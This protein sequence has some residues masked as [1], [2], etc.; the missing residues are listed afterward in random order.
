MTAMYTALATTTLSSSASS[1]TF[2][3]IPQG[4]RDLMLVFNGEGTGDR[5]MYINPNGDT[6]NATAVIMNGSGSSAN[7]FTLTRIN[8]CGWTSTARSQSITHIMDYAATDKHKTFISRDTESGDRVAA[9]AFRWA[10]T[11]AITSI[12]IEADQFSMA[13]GSTF[14]LYGIAGGS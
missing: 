13:A 1:V 10:S 14:S 12:E 7:S 6:A 3:S 9:R 5:F 11:S 4:Y 8:F 2:S